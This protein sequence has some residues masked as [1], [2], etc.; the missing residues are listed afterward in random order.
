[1]EN[2]EDLSVVDHWVVGFGAG[3]FAKTESHR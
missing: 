3:I 1:M 2:L